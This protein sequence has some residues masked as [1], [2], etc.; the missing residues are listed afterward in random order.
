MAS[1]IEVAEAVA[2]ALE[3]LRATIPELQISAYLQPVP[4]PLSIDVYPAPNFQQPSGFEKDLDTFWVVRAR[5]SS[6][7]H[8]SAQ[9]ALLRLL[10][11]RAPESVEEAL[12]VDQSLGGAAQAV[13]VTDQGVSGY[14]ELAEEQGDGR[15]VSCEWLIGVTP[16]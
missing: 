16:T 4:T 14:S 2:A 11:R 13:W 1:L 9:Q 5:T 3:P 15:L 10:D 12:T 7:D 6:G 8:T